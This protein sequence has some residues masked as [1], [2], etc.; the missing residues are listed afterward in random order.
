MLRH[1]ADFL[2]RTIDMNSKKYLALEILRHEWLPFGTS[3]RCGPC[4]ISIKVRF[5]GEKLGKPN[6]FEGRY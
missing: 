2:S 3:T 5:T 1:G 4:A 6:L